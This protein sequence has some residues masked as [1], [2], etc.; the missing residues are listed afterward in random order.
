M[1]VSI[2]AC[3]VGTE[4]AIGYKN[5]LICHIKE[6]LK[7]FKELTKGHTVIMGYNTW[8]SLPKKPLGHRNNIVI[9]NDKQV[10]IGFTEDD[11]TYLVHGIDEAISKAKELNETE[12]FIIGGESIFGQVLDQNLAD[13]IYLTEVDEFDYGNAD[14]F[15]P[16]FNV[17]EFGKWF[18]NSKS[19]WCLE[20]RHGFMTEIEGKP[21]NYCFSKYVNLTPPKKGE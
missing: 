15:F 1:N 10:N 17:P 8:M 5:G 7:R 16:V 20:S 14:K 18:P 21:V 11:G 9:S 3:V 4:M 2:I 12:A 6:D 13:F 19:N